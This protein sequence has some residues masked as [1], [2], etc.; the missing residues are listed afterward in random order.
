[1]GPV[2]LKHLVEELDAE[3]RGGVVSK[4]CQP[5]ERTLVLKVFKHGATVSVLI[6]ANPAF[7]RM[8]IIKEE[9]FVNPPRPLRLCAY[10]R[11]RITGARIEGVIQ[12]E[13]ERIARIDL[14]KGRVPDP[15]RFTLIA[16]LTGKSSNVIL[17]DSEGVVLE[18]M[19]RFPPETSVRAVEPGLPLAPLPSLKGAGKGEAAV[20]VERRGR[21]SWNE[22]AERHYSAL[23][24]EQ[25]AVAMRNA[26]RRAIARAEK[27]AA[28]KVGNLEGD[29]SRAQRELAFYGVGELL[30]ANL[31]RASRGMT[32]VE[33]V[34]YTKVPPEKVAIKLDPKLS[35]RENM[36]KYFK[37]ARKA[38]VALGLLKERIPRARAETEYIASLYYELD[39]AVGTEDLRAVE[40]ELIEG[41]YIKQVREKEKERAAR[42]EPVRRSTSSEGFE[43]LCGKS[44][45]G[46]DLIVKKYAGREDIWLHAS[47]VPGSHVLIKVDGRRGELTKKTIEEAAAFAAFHSKARACG[48]VE[49]VYTEA[50]H[51]KK[52]RGA[53]PGSVTISAFKSIRVR[54]RDMEQGA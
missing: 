24:A 1:M 2:L 52:P 48:L 27:R 32:E 19:K 11:S 16:E 6:S 42:P 7:P 51:V 29:R 35:P 9:A 8:H 53:K 33:A 21:E 22:A 50:K 14:A 17:V 25:A 40:E 49:V 28:R 15:E 5:D 12:P 23:A 4:V 43:V 10:L 31:G 54:P 41:G 36:D 38:K 20:E 45:P 37:R 30:A 44:G 26:L 18:S 34:D 46:N 3:L 13:G 47:G 39:D